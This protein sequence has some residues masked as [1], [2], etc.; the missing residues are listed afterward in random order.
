VIDEYLFHAINQFAGR[1]NLLDDTLRWSQTDY[2]KTVPIMMIIWGLWFSYPERER[3]VQ[4][5]LTAIVVLCLVVV[6]AARLAAVL[7][8][9]RYRPLHTPGL[10]INLAYE[11]NVKLLDGWSAMPSDHAAFFFALSAGLMMLNRKAGIVAAVLSLFVVCLPRIYF[12]W[13]WPSD[14]VAGAALGILIM[15]LFIRPVDGLIHRIGVIPYFMARPWV[16]YPLFFLATFEMSQMF[17]LS[18][19]ILSNIVDL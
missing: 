14:I 1:S 19:S 6:L 13:H 15:V 3:Q 9:F 2:F 8:P 16:G 10:E 5:R 18:R 17:F 7:L 4:E 11:Q 12:G